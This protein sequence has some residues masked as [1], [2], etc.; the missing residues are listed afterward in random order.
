MGRKPYVD[1]ELQKNISQLAVG[2]AKRG[3]SV[4]IEKLEIL[5]GLFAVVEKVEE[6]G[7]HLRLV[8]DQRMPNMYW[9]DPPW[10]GLG[11]PGAVAFME[12]LQDEEWETWVVKGDVPDCFYRW[13]VPLEMANWFGIPFLTFEE[14]AVELEALGEHVVVK[15]MLQGREREKMIGVGLG[16]VAMGWSWAV[17]LAQEGLV[18]VVEQA[19]ERIQKEEKQAQCYILRLLTSKKI[20][21]TCEHI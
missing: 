5:V 3:L 1:P 10:V 12:I 14:L 6:G 18:G 13:G 11:G 15:D 8:L 21:E 17:L 2:M 20:T 7:I 16:V 19:G 9:K 4:R